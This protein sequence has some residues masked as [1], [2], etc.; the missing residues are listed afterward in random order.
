MA[1]IGTLVPVGEL[2]AMAKRLNPRLRRIG[3]PWNP[4]QTNSETYT[5]MARVTAP[6]LGLELI[7]GN[8]EA[9]TAVGEVVA[10]LVGRGAE[11]ILT[12]GDLTVSLAID[13]VV[14]EARR[15]RIPV[16]ATQPSLATHGVL[17]AMGGDYYL[18]GRETGDL[19]ARVMNGE[20]ISRIPILYQLPLLLVINRSATIGLRETWTFPPDVLARAREV[21]ATS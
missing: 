3:L 8:V 19:A 6:G 2:L 21:K 7:E 17:L 18:I 9:T 13:A 1:G 4:S 20:D 10:S 15:A 14:A 16:F 11:A 12:T 5:R